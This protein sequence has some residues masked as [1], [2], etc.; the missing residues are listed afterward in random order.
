MFEGYGKL[1][2]WIERFIT[3]NCKNEKLMNYNWNRI[4]NIFCII[5]F[6]WLMRAF[7]QCNYCDVVSKWKR[8]TGTICTIN[9]AYKKWKKREKC[10]FWPRP[11][12]WWIITG[13]LY[14]IYFS[15]LIFHDWWELFFNLTIVLWYQNGKEVL[16]LY[17]EYIRPLKSAKKKD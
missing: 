10:E 2:C 15:Y 9:K 7:S 11:Y 3:M 13:T 6:S 4:Y 5:D 14:T 12:S 17:L 8:I 16:E 1:V